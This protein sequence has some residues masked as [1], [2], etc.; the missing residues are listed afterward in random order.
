VKR[1]KM[2]DIKDKGIFI[3]QEGVGKKLSP[4]IKKEVTDADIAKVLKKLRKNYDKDK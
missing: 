3:N 4:S 1:W 2:S